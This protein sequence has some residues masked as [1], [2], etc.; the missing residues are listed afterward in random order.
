MKI[1]HPACASPAKVQFH[2]LVP[3]AKELCSFQQFPKDFVDELTHIVCEFSSQARL[4]R[5][6][7][8]LVP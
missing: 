6:V 2:G 8:R 1:V 3:D 5:Q 4:F 7:E